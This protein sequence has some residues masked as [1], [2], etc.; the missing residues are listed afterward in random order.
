MRITFDS[1]EELKTFCRTFRLE[2]DGHPTADQRKATDESLEQ[3]ESAAPRVKTPEPA[4]KPPA[5]RVARKS[6]GK[7]QVER[8]RTAIEGF[9]KAGKSF[10]ANDVLEKVLAGDRSLNF[11][12]VLTGI[13]KMMS[14]E[15]ASLSFTE[16]PGKGPRPVKVYHPG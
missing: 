16:K 1:V 6:G 9:C 3:T 11:R 14:T 2:E 10:S 8:I 15:Y 12:S 4:S 5:E 7:T 13:S